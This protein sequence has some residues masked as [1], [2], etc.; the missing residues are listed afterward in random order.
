MLKYLRVCLYL[1]LLF[2]L[3][4][5][6]DLFDSSEP[7]PLPPGYQY[8]IPWPSLADSPWPMNHHDPQNTG[9][10]RMPGPKMGV[11]VWE[12]VPGYGEVT[13]GIS[14]GPDS[15]IYVISSW[16]S[17]S[18]LFCLNADG[19]LKWKFD[20]GAYPNYATPIITVQN[21][22]IFGDGLSTIYCLNADGEVIWSTNLNTQY[23]RNASFAID[24]TGNIYLT[25]PEGVLYCLNQN[26]NVMWEYQDDRIFSNRPH[27]YQM[28]F[29][30]DGKTLYIPGDSV[31]VIAF[32]INSLEV[33]WTY[34]DAILVNSIVA[35]AYGNIYVFQQISGNNSKPLVALDTNG[36]VKWIYRTNVDYVW[37]N[38]PAIDWN[39]N[40]I[41]AADTLYSVNYKGELN[42]KRTLPDRCNAPIICDINNNIYVGFDLSNGSGVSILCYD[43]KGNFN[44]Q[45]DDNTQNWI[46]GS[47]AIGFEGEI[48]CPLSPE[49]I[50]K[51]L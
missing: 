42:W 44:W 12:F 13:S 14:I 1:S 51:I 15:S 46:A 18:G 45:I 6:C 17:H 34:G 24:K 47:A 10:S 30:P 9:R 20:L 4:T 36:K 35:D 2:V 26:G 11:V 3:L 16:Q 8:D 37:D 38:V 28:V 19:S 41:F 25:D 50:L 22:L 29:S 33:K 5:T 49:K 21:N 40:I 23:L 43:S 39:G 7:K 32:D 48:I 27:I 31:S